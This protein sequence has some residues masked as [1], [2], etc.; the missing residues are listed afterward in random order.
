MHN[1]TVTRKLP[2]FFLPLRDSFREFLTIPEHLDGVKRSS[3]ADNS[4]SGFD[5]VAIFQANASGATILDD[6]LINVR[7][8]LITG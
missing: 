2:E 5:N 1:R 8:Q 7:V 6:D 3:I 4:F